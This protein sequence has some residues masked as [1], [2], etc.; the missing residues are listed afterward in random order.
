MTVDPGSQRCGAG[1]MLLQWGLAIADRMGVE[2]NSLERT[3]HPSL[4]H[5]AL[6]RN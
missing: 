4:L 6:W 3:L 2:V 1:R 5:V